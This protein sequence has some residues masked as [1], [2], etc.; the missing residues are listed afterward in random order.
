[1]GYVLG[2]DLGTTYSGAALGENGHVEML[3]LGT[4]QATIPS[5]V[6]LRDD[7]EVLTG[8]AAERRSITE[9]GRTAREFKRRLGDPAPIIV[10]G[11]PYGAE[12]LMAHLMRAIVARATEQK[13]GPPERVVIT[14]PASWGPYKLDLLMQ[15]ARQADL[16]QVELVSEP[17]AAAIHYTSQERIEPGSIV[18]VYDFGGGTFDAAVLRRTEDGFEQLGDAEGLERLGG[19]DFDAAVLAHVGE[20]LDGQLENGQDDSSAARTALAKLREDCVGA[21]ETLSVDTEA[22]IPVLLPRIQTEVRLTRAE[23]EDIVRP[24]IRETI[25]ALERAVRSAGKEM[26]EIDRILLVG[27][28]SRIPLIGQMVREA[29]GRPVAVDAQPKHAIALGAST[30]GLQSAAAGVAPESTVETPA[31][32]ATA[33]LVPPP[34]IPAGEPLTESEEPAGTEPA[35]PKTAAPPVAPPAPEPA[36]E[37]EPEPE[38][39]PVAAAAAPPPPR[40]PA[41][42]GRG[43]G[44][45]MPLAAFVAIPVVAVVAAVGAFLVF[46]GGNNDTAANPDDDATP[47]EAAE[48]PDVARTPTRQAAVATSTPTPTNTPTPTPTRPPQYSEITTIATQGNDYVVNFRVEGFQPNIQSIHVHFFW[49]TI[50]P[51]QAG[52]PANPGNWI[53]YGGP[54][55]FRGYKVSDRPPGA[56]QMCILVAN[57]DHSVRLNTGNC[58]DLPN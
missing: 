52:I 2:I 27:G 19:I 11:T 41:G 5:V 29:T 42:S 21:K 49:D 39:E 31:S 14:H 23:F 1:V 12:A 32:E 40:E 28:T 43:G 34:V 33:P 26:E 35:P 25:S 22:T 53:L 44:R 58:V 48:T 24:R 13:G 46:N 38:P 50:P 51:E 55:P 17:V 47:T 3:Q 54:S 56:Q 57:A 9:P 37:A 18:A 10:G 36:A 15:A 7:G 20:S 6:V 30:V 16:L 4:R 8:E 45:R